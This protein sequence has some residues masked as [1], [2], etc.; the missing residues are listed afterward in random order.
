MLRKLFA[1]VWI[2]LIASACS[3]SRMSAVKDS[4]FMVNGYEMRDSVMEAVMVAVHDTVVEVT[5]ITVQQNEAGDTLRLTTVTDRTKARRCDAIAM[6]QTKVET[7]KDTV[8][9][10]HRDSVLVSTS[11]G[12]AGSPRVSSV[13]L[14]FKWV[15]WII[16]SLIVLFIFLKLTKLFNLK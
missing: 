10:E 2:V 8:Y 13:V 6:Q 16:V 11:D 5:T 7:V 4:R 9:M 3:S 14:T 1:I 12:S 15:F